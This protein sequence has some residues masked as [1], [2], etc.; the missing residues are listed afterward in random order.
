M[1]PFEKILDSVFL[2][3]LIKSFQRFMLKG[4]FYENFTKKIHIKNLFL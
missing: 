4:F 1:I 2:Q 3:I